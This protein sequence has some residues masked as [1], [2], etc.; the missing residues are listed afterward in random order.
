MRCHS[1]SFSR[2]FFCASSIVDLEFG[3][4][5]TLIFARPPSERPPPIACISDDDAGPP[6]WVGASRRRRP[7]V[8]RAKQRC[9]GYVSAR[10]R[11]RALAHVGG[12]GVVAHLEREPC[13]SVRSVRVA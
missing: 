3:D 2:R 11:E 1:V 7:C 12:R 8:A 5:S 13:A 10:V 4:M 6:N 9:G